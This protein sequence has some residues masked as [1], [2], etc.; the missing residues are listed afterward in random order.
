MVGKMNN[1]YTCGDVFWQFVRLALLWSIIY[2]TWFYAEAFA[3]TQKF[4]R[5]G[6]VKF[7]SLVGGA[8]AYYIVNVILN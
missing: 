7:L 3:T 5:P 2:F 4:D 8:F 1:P 6:L